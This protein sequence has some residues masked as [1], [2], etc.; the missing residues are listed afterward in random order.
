MTRAARLSSHLR[1]F[2]APINAAHDRLNTRFAGLWWPLS[3]PSPERSLGPS[4]HALYAVHVGI[5][6]L[7]VLLLP[8]PRRPTIGLLALLGLGSWAVFTGA[9]DR[10]AFSYGTSAPDNVDRRSR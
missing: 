10:R 2:D 6:T 3:P 4:E 5:A 9:W 7:A 8:V 1:R